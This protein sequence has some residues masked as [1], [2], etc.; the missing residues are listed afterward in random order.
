MWT[1]FLI[2][3]VLAVYV[4]LV[5]STVTV[6]LLEN[7]QPAKTIAWTIVLVMLPV[8]GLIIFYF[9]GQNVRKERYIGKRLYNLL[10]QRMLGEVSRL[11]A[12]AYPP[13]HAPLILSLIH[14]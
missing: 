4:I 1:T 6:V 3:T 10:T 13:K 7:R 5:A 8:I 9:F 12:G 2:W 11:P 14:I